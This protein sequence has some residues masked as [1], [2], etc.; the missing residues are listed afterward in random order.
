MESIIYLLTEFELLNLERALHSICRARE[1]PFSSEKIKRTAL[2]NEPVITEGELIV[3]PEPQK[4]LKIRVRQTN[5]TDFKRHNKKYQFDTEL[6][7]ADGEAPRVFMKE[8]Y[9]E[10]Q[11]MIPEHF[12]SFEH[13]TD[14]LQDYTQTDIASIPENLLFAAQQTVRELLSGYTLRGTV[15]NRHNEKRQPAR[16]RQELKQDHFEYVD[17]NRYEIYE[18]DGRIIACSLASFKND[19]LFEERQEYALDVIA[20]NSHLELVNELFD[21]K[22]EK[23]LLSDNSINGAKL[24]GRQELIRMQKPVSLDDLILKPKTRD[25]LETEVFNFFRNEAYY[26]KADLPFKRGVALYGPPG[27]G[28]TMLAKVIA[29]TFDETVIWIKAGDL[30]EIRDVD[31]I[32]QLARTGAP[33]VIIFEDID[34][35]TRDREIQTDNRFLANFMSHL[36]GLEENDGILTLI[37]TNRP[38]M[39]EDA[40]INRPGRIDCKIEI[41]ELESEQIAMLLDKKLAPLL[42]DFDSVAEFIPGSLKLS[43]ARTVETA[44]R[45]MQ[46]AAARAGKTGTPAEALTVTAEDITRALKESAAIQNA[47]RMGFDSL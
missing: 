27:S 36:D 4:P 11:G 1:I 9:R 26:R 33:S 7:E 2:F 28:K 40:V 14:Y 30:S 8:L 41:G 15:A 31:R 34:M 10:I 46:H 25:A 16:R 21:Q 3:F 13:L 35:Y 22:F 29:S 43:G 39:I 47:G 45:I 32:F 37:T 20:G 17:L 18:K 6:T 44:T 5:E 38:D 42:Q 23:Q 12:V 24:T 19:F